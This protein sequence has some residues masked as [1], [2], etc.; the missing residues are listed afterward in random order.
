MALEGLCVPTPTLFTPQGDLD[1]DRNARFIAG[2]SDAGVPHLFVLGSLGEFTSL[3][4]AERNQLLRAVSTGLKGE[5]DLWVGVG[6]PATRRAVRYARE[7]EAAGAAVLVAVP[8]FYL[9]PTEEGIAA[10]YRAIHAAVGL[11]LLAYNIPAKVGYALRPPLVHTLVREGTLRGL[12]DTSGTFESVQGFLDGAPK[13][14]VVFPGD[15]PLAVASLRAGA[16]GVVMG[17]G[18]IAPKLTVQLVTATRTG[19]ADTADRLQRI[20]DRLGHVVAQ[21]PFPATGKFLAR[22]LRSAPDGYRSP[23]DAL[24]ASEAERVRAALD[25]LEPDLRPFL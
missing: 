20:V 11:P 14:M 24:T 2:L 6:A 19:A 8:P 16:V 21:G 23:H 4:D 22:L 10:Y 7:A 15:D 17:L 13:G 9:P 25:P 18:N 1:A 3:E 12:K 5:S